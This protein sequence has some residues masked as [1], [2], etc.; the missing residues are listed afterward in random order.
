MADPNYSNPETWR[1]SQIIKE[2]KFKASLS[3]G[4]GGQN[5]NKV[6]TK[7]ELYWTPASSGIL[8]E[9]QKAK[10]NTKLSNKLSNEGELRLV[11]EEER[12]QLRNK[13][14]VSGKFYALL[15]GCFKEKK[16]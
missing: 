14:K 1:N 5:V 6:S 4:K 3:G 10:V 9:S 2:V 12:S 7:V 13:E 16:K 8:S 15:A 11:S